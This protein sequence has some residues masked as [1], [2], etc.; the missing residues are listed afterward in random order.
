MALDTIPDLLAAI[1]RLP[2]A[3]RHRARA[4]VAAAIDRPAPA[5]RAALGLLALDLAPAVASSELVIDLGGLEP[6][7]VAASG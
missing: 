3:Q 2:A 4:R 1:D 6:V 5:A 7:A